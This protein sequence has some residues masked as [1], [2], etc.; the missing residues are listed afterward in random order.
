MNVCMSLQLV[1]KAWWSIVK[2]L[3]GAKMQISKKNLPP[4]IE[5]GRFFCS[6]EEK[7]E[8]FNDY[9]CDQNTIDDSYVSLPPNILYFQTTI[10]LSNIH[11]SK[12]EINDLVKNVYVSKACGCDGVGNKILKIVAN[13]ITQAVCVTARNA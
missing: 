11:A 3:Y 7:A 12:Q 9:F 13:G 2:S 6:S 5:G 8:L 4:L 10:I 1:L